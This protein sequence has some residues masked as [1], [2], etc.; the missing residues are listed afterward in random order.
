M[1]HIVTTGFIINLPG[2]FLVQVIDD[3]KI[4]LYTSH[5]RY[6][7]LHKVYAPYSIV[8]NV[9]L[10]TTIMVVAYTRMGLTLYRSEF[11]S[12]DKHQ[13]QINLFQTCV[14]M[15]VM[16]TL[17]GSNI[18]IAIMLFAVGFYKDMSGSHYTISVI[19]MVFNQ[20][21]NPYIYCLRYKEFQLQLKQMFCSNEKQE[22]RKTV[23][24]GG[25]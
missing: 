16:F 10:P 6:P 21:I 20:C 15:M 14:I 1:Y 5:I 4:C 11:S 24:S 25:G 22:E 13:A 18:C 23:G 12:K 19:L 9:L 8:L 7:V 2:A 3:I 17:S